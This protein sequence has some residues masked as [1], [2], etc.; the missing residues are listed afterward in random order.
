M[1]N[2]VIS[3]TIEEFKK[4]SLRG[5]ELFFQLEKTVSFLVSWRGT[6]YSIPFSEFL[7]YFDPNRNFH[8]TRPATEK[9]VMFHSIFDTSKWH[10]IVEVYFYAEEFVGVGKDG[11]ML[12]LYSYFDLLQKKEI[13]QEIFTELVQKYSLPLGVYKSYCQFVK[14]EIEHYYSKNGDVPNYIKNRADYEVL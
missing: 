11:N 5:D 6:C 3:L 13:D 8:K 14:H 2:D 4:V 10:F 7:R 12:Q 9:K 1:T